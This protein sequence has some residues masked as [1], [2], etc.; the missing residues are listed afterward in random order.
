M[1][2]LTPIKKLK[3][4]NNESE[5]AMS[6]SNLTIF[7]D[8]GS[9]GNP[10]QAGIGI[11]VLDDQD[12]EIHS[13]GDAI[14]IATNNEAEYK[15]FLVSLEWLQQQK[16]VEPESVSWKLDSKLVVEQLNKNWKVKEPRMR[17]L[18]EQAW[19]MLGTL[20]CSY[21]ITHVR[22]EHN[23]RADQLVNQALDL[24]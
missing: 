3:Q 12:Q 13:W 10:G 23:K 20:P 14:G 8:G 1:H 11:S 24:L 22:R 7:T 18:A 21:K 4:K 9:R 19:E 15:A 2:Q 17:A 5:F 6:S 16:K